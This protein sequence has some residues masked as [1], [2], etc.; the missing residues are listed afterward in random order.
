M[1]PHVSYFS[2]AFLF[3]WLALLT[4]S[5]VLAQDFDG[6][7]VVI[8]AKHSNKVLGVKNNSN[9]DLAE[10]VQTSAVSDYQ[11]FK[12]FKNGENGDAYF[13]RNVGSGKLLEWKDGKLVVGATPKGRPNRDQIQGRLW[14]IKEVKKVIRGRQVSTGFY[15]I[16][17]KDNNK[18]LDVEGSQ[19]QEGA[20]VLVWNPTQNE[21]Q[22]F[23]L[24][25]VQTETASKRYYSITYL[26]RTNVKASEAPSSQMVTR[27]LSAYSVNDSKDVIIVNEDKDAAP[28]IV[29]RTRNGNKAE[30][31]RLYYKDDGNFFKDIFPGDLITFARVREGEN[32]EE[33]PGYEPFKVVSTGFL[34]EIRVG[35]E[36]MSYKESDAL[37][38]DPDASSYSYD[39]RYLDPQEPFLVSQYNDRTGVRKKIF[40]ELEDDP[41]DWYPSPNGLLKSHFDHVQNHTAEKKISS[42]YFYSSA[43]FQKS[44]TMGAS[45]SGGIAEGPGTPGVTGTL[46]GGFSKVQGNSSVAER[47]YVVTGAS[48]TLFDILL[49]PKK[50]ELKSEFVRD[51]KALPKTYS[52]STKNRF[53][54]FIE[55]YGTHYPT[56]VTYGGRVSAFTSMT[57]DEAAEFQSKS[58]NIGREVEASIQGFEVGQS[59][60]FGGSRTQNHGEIL[61]KAKHSEHAYGGTLNGENWQVDPGNVM[62]VSFEFNKIPAL[63]NNVNGLSSW[64][65]A[66]TQA[67]DA[68]LAE[69]PKLNEEEKDVYAIQM[70]YME[71]WESEAGNSEIFGTVEYGVGNAFRHTAWDVHYDNHIVFDGFKKI[72]LPETIRKFTKEGNK[73]HFYV[74]ANIG[75][76]ARRGEGCENCNYVSDVQRCYVKDHNLGALPEHWKMT[77]NSDKVGKVDIHY[78]VWK[79]NGINSPW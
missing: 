70:D 15:N 69:C 38:L 3:L 77:M 47:L 57:Y 14:Q 71:I 56:K 45:V 53:I 64:K 78:Y 74:K 7:T 36:Q 50:M 67:I 30:I 27:K 58:W 35:R 49:I 6:K 76:W 46:S 4:P 33:N 12:F 11:K 75:E 8:R 31:G 73:D 60:D 29:Y 42:Q 13:L 24:E 18:Q 21:N 28:L 51:V 17:L 68:V 2:Y 48:V 25:V 26:P 37:P 1:K 16:I 62:P 10:V 23:A 66:L 65:N 20:R 40:S 41:Y 34:L 32:T 61:S 5:I 39:I 22:L 52:Q 54:A 55:K 72:D 63:F 59:L 19:T 43:D 9:K 44:F 79:V